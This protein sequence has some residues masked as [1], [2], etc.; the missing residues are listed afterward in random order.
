VDIFDLSGRPVAQVG[1][2]AH[3][4]GTARISWDGRDGGGELVPPGLYLYRLKVGGTASPTQQAGTFA[5][6]Y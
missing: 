2:V 6:V 3:T 4:A 5:L 1:P